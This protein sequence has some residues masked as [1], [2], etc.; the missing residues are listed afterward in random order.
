MLRFIGPLFASILLTLASSPAWSDNILRRVP[1]STAEQLTAAIL[2]AQPG[3]LISIA[4]GRYRMKMRFTSDTSGT[5]RN[6]VILAPRDGSDTVIVD[7]TGNQI[8]I[9]FSNAKHIQLRMLNI[10]GGGYHGVFFDNG[11]QNIVIDGNRIYDN[12]A[13]Q[14]LNS[15]AELKGSGGK[16][17]PRNIIIANNE[18]FHSHHPPGGN[19]QGIDCNFCTD[20]T[21]TGNYLHDIREPTVE[22]HSHYDRGSC[23]QMKSTS[24][25]AVIE[26]NRIARCHIG[27]VYGGEGL[28]SPE[29]I[30]GIVRN[31]VIYDSTEIGIAAVNV[32]GGRV[33]HNTLFGNGES[34]RV[35]RDTRNPD[36]ENSVDIANNVLGSPVRTMDAPRGKVGG[37]FVL[38]AGVESEL[39][40]DL[41]ARD[42]RLRAGA[43]SLI[44]KAVPLKEPIIGDFDDIPRPYGIAADIGAFEYRPT[45]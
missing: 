32:S 39:F 31:N 4:P 28:A 24:R 38:K 13:Q 36:S 30:G 19:F 8:T 35:A 37:N 12:H 43:S 1:V 3:D 16:G 34:I 20:F 27:I 44:D 22:S 7:G 15:H 6:P 5:K 2:T 10:T 23:I 40:R 21:I 11:A 26:R 18:I 9:K 17:R 41:S 33:V 14:P 45:N 42:F 25:N 29:H